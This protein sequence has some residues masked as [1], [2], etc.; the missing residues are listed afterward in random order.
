MGAWGAGIFDGDLACEVRDAFIDRIG[1]GQTPA[2]ATRAMFTGW[3]DAFAD[4]E[5]GPVMWLALAEA[6]WDLGRLQPPVLKQARRVLRDGSGLGT[7]DGK[8][9]VKRRAELERLEAKLARKLPAPKRIPRRKLRE[10]QLRPGDLFAFALPRRKRALLWVVKLS[11]DK[12]GACPVLELLDW[13][14]T[15]PPALAAIRSLP[16]RRTRLSYDPWG[17]LPAWF[18]VLDFARRVDPGGQ[19]VLLAKGFKPKRKLVDGFG[20][21]AHLEQ[22]FV[23]NVQ[24]ELGL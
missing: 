17:Q 15:K 19:Y 7:F 2:A 1:N 9:L 24:R 18:Y 6:Q 20:P 3:K 5:D 10:T 11:V 21:L 12:G 22:R 16:A 14:G 8:W 23:A 13:K 4:P